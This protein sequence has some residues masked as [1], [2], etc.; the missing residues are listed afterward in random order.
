[1]GHPVG[2]PRLV[3]PSC[4]AH[5]HL[6]ETALTRE[7]LSQGQATAA[8]GVQ[9]SS[10]DFLCASRLERSHTGGG[11]SLDEVVHPRDSLPDREPYL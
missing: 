1:M 4:C 7:W 5:A 2:R 8:L 3:V 6:A 10:L 9:K 11:H